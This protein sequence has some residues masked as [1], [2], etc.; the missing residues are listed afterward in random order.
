MITLADVLQALSGKRFESLAATRVQGFVLDH[1]QVRADSVFVAIPGT[2]VDGHDF[3]RNA[4]DAG[5][6]AVLVNAEKA[7]RLSADGMT[8]VRVDQI[9]LAP[10][11]I[12]A[13]IVIAVDNTERALQQLAAWWR[14]RLTTRIIGVTGSVGKTTT[15]EL[16]AQ[17][18]SVRHNVLKSEGNQNNALGVPLTLLKLTPAHDYAVIEMGMD[19]PG[20]IAA[21]CSWAKP[22]IGVITLIAPVHM[23]RLGSLAAIAEEKSQLVR[24]LPEARDGG[25]AVLNDDD[26]FVSAMSAVTSGRIVSYGLT[27]RATVW[28]D[29]VESRGLD[30]VSFALHFG[31]HKV[32]A[33]I[34]LMGEHSVHT[35][36][37][38]AA[39]A[40]AEGMSLDEIAEGLAIEAEQLRLVVGEGPHGSIVIDD[41][42]NA[43]PQSM[44]SA[45]NLLKEINGSTHRVAVLG[46]MFE[47]GDAEESGHEEVGCRAA[48][49]ANT[50][51]CVGA[52]SK[53]TARAA[54]E[55]GAKRENV[56]HVDDN[57]AAIQLLRR[58]IAQKSIVLV[59]GSRG[60]KMEEIVYAL[61]GAA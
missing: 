18:L 14:S 42:Y 5:A 24:A 31:A 59:K 51:V 48:S 56:H 60:M 41:T 45:L 43:S 20:E 30:G 57:A 38:A 44:I 58:L 9:A 4:L 32:R 37:R 52:R 15:K 19:Q 2:R 17:V 39:V 27:P 12:N 47:L 36:L 54:V 33:R 26:D 49:V 16:I 25:V 53:V 50:I 8:I 35:A 6:C 34:K 55:C 1:R 28:A 22:D 13:P 10:E 3:A 40:T 46:D 29:D 61:G 7:A 21:Y 11:G 23:E